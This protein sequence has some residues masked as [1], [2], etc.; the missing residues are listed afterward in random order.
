MVVRQKDTATTTVRVYKYG[1]VPKGPFPE[2]AIQELWRANKLWNK[3]VEIERNH[4]AAFDEARRTAS[5]PYRLLAEKLDDLSAQIDK[6]YDDKR[7]AR[8]IAGTTDATN[9]LIQSANEVIKTLQKERKSLYE[10]LKP[11]RVQATKLVD[12]KAFNQNLKDKRNEAV[13]M[14]GLYSATAWDVLSYFQDAEKKARKTHSKIRKHRF[15]GTGFISFRFRR[16]GAKVD[17][18]FVDELYLGNKPL[19]KNN[20]R[21]LFVERD[22]SRKKTRIT[23][24]ATLAG[25]RKKASKTVHFFDLIYHREIPKDAKIQ[26]GKIIRTR[27]GDKFSYHLVLTVKQPIKPLQVVSDDNAIGIDIGFRRTESSVKVAAIYDMEDDAFQ[28]IEAPLKMI[29]AMAHI[30]NLKSTIDDEATSLGKI[31]KPL[32]LAAPLDENHDKYNLWKSAAKYPNNVTLSFET[33]YKL[34]RW[35]LY[36]PGHFPEIAERHVLQWWKGNSRKYRELHNA[37]RKQLTHRKHFYRQIAFS[38]VS[39]KR[40]IVFEKIDLSK[41]AAIK[42]VDNNLGNKARAQ[43]FSVSPSEFRDAI[44]NAAEREN[45]PWIEINPSYTS[46]DCSEC[47]WRNKEL[48]TETEWRCKNCGVSHDRDVNAAKNIAKRGLEK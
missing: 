37:R 18:V 40:L 3:L 16:D 27:V 5:K 26:N 30:E 21:L 48:G 13:R 34:A 12:V 41:F 47:G 23:M 45:V 14:S 9:P 31:I 43:R 44:K 25:G 39:K 29:K 20:K 7:N 24:R 11:I 17:S 46:Q 4:R 15:D 22:D 28:E 42:D 32:L 38:L 10:A 2:E 6:A 1:I 35:I 8:Q 36:A 19:E 33:A